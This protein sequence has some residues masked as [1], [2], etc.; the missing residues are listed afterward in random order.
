MRDCSKA[1]VARQIPRGPAEP[2]NRARSPTCA[3]AAHR[4]DPRL[5]RRGRRHRSARCDG[6]RASTSA[7]NCAVAG[8][9]SPF[10]HP[11]PG[12]GV[13]AQSA[14]VTPPLGALPSCCRKIRKATLLITG[15]EPVRFGRPRAFPNRHTV[16]IEKFDAAGHPRFPTNSASRDSPERSRSTDR[17]PGTTCSSGALTLTNTREPRLAVRHHKTSTN[18]GSESSVSAPGVERWSRL[19]RRR[20]THR[21]AIDGLRV[22]LLQSPHRRRCTLPS[23]S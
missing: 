23:A 13:A 17:S 18:P 10:R 8:V 2:T 9:G 1:G 14:T 15:S 12:V 21:C 3:R 19:R 7:H 4:T 22:H 20:T 6:T 16:D 5:A 11:Y